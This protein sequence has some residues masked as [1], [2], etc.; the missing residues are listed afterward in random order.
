MFVRPTFHF[1]DLNDY[2]W[3][4]EPKLYAYLTRTGNTDIAHY[5]GFGDFRVS[6]GAP[7]GWN[8]P[9]RCAKAPARPTAASTR[10]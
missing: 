8:W 4:F 9:P 2:H 5:R 1:G 10:N 7:N 6:Y 3:K